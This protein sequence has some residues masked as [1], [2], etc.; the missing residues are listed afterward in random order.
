M[1]L[2]KLAEEA[3]QLSFG[4]QISSIGQS[5][6]EAF[7][8][9]VDVYHYFKVSGYGSGQVRFDVGLDIGE[10]LLRRGCSAGLSV[11]EE[12]GLKDVAIAVDQ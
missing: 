4:R 12:L 1:A 5:F 9:C 2:V 8:I 10:K 3:F 11:L 7:L 6:G